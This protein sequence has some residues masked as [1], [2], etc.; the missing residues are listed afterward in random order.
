MCPHWCLEKYC[1][2]ALARYIYQPTQ[3]YQYSPPWS[4]CRLYMQ[5]SCL[6]FTDYPQGEPKSTRWTKVTLCSAPTEP[7]DYYAKRCT[8]MST[9]KNALF[10]ATPSVSKSVKSLSGVCVNLILLTGVNM[11][12]LCIQTRFKVRRGGHG[13]SNLPSPPSYVRLYIPPPQW[14]L[15]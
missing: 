4:R 8:D 7:A 9:D 1:Y 11:F 15:Q 5:V 14:L 13:V 2:W 6:L 10:D 12:K 3:C